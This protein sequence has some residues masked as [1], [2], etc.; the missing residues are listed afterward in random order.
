MD[1]ETIEGRHRY[2]VVR[3]IAHGGMGSVYE[4]RQ[5]GAEGFSKTVAVKSIRARFA[6]DDEFK[7]LFVGEAKLVA[8]LVHENI[9][10]VYHLGV[11]DELYFIVME[12]VAGITLERFIRHH[13]DHE[14]P[15]PVE[16]GAFIASRI[17]RGLEYAHARRDS[18]GRPLGIVHRDIS[19]KNVLLSFEGVVKLTDFGIAKAR[20]VMEQDEKVLMGRMEYMSP[21]QARRRGTDRR[22]DLYSVGVLTY[23][24][25]TGTLPSRG[26]GSLSRLHQMGVAFSRPVQ[27]AR[28]EVPDELAAIIDRALQPEPGD[29]FQTAGEMGYALEYHLYRDGY[30]PTNVTLGDYLK[31]SFAGDDPSLPEP[32]EERRE[33]SGRIVQHRAETMFGKSLADTEAETIRARPVETVADRE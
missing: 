5:L 28:R 31:A 3:L 27:A 11:E 32:L 23:E 13:L 10:Q 6:K 9:V 33:G 15:L 16:L 1:I 7:R 12:Y 4:A 17:C 25:L 14:I 20:E 29:R 19:P 22:S 24:I 30:G 26:A 18:S 2:R 8:D 21:E